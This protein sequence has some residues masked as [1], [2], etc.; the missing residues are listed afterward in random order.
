[1]NIRANGVLTPGSIHLADYS[2]PRLFSGYLT[3]ITSGFLTFTFLEPLFKPVGMDLAIVALYV[4]SI[5]AAFVG[6]CLGVLLP[7]IMPGVCFGSSVALVGG[8]LATV[9]NPFYFPI[10]SLAL[11]AIGG[12]M[13]VRYVRIVTADAIQVRVHLSNPIPDPI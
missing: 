2:K 8:C 3:A 7:L 10:A 6:M 9:L 1:M 13:S 11:S 4:L 12:F 5:N